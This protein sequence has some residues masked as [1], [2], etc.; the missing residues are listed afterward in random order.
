M[1]MFFELNTGAKDPVVG[2][3][4]WQADARGIRGLVIAVVKKVATIVNPQAPPRLHQIL[5][6]LLQRPLHRQPPIPLLYPLQL[7]CPLRRHH[8]RRHQVRIDRRAEGDQGRGGIRA[9]CRPS[10]RRRRQ[11]RDSRRSPFRYGFLF[12]FVFEK[13]GIGVRLAMGELCAETWFLLEAYSM[14]FD[15]IAKLLYMDCSQCC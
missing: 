2:L 1:T 8:H 12:I 11:R 5:L 13:W 14:H 10:I 7:P 9:G 6:R 3:G 15:T 4:T